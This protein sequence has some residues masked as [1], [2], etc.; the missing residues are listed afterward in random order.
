MN[1][2][3]SGGSTTKRSQRKMKTKME[4]NDVK[5][6]QGGNKKYFDRSIIRGSIGNQCLPDCERDVRRRRKRNI[7]FSSLETG[8][9]DC[10]FKLEMAFETNTVESN[11]PNLWTIDYFPVTE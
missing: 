6:I 9:F 5:G 4:S 3:I 1:H 7:P 8:N 11:L 2:D 10:Q